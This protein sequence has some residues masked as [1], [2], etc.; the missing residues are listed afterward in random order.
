MTLAISGPPSDKPFAFYDLRSRSLRTWQDTDQKDSPMFSGTVPRTGSMFSGYLYEHPTPVPPTGGSD[1]SLQLPTPMAR[2]FDKGFS[3]SPDDMSRLSKLLPTP[4]AGDATA[5][6]NATATRCKTPPTGI[7]AGIT[8]TDF[9]RLLPT[10]RTTDAHGSGNHGT[11]G[12][13]LRTTIASL[14]ESTSRPSVVGRECL[15]APHLT[16][17][18]STRTDDPV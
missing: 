14:G 4:I 10:P 16:R 18:N 8:L 1:C 6:C 12:Q 3:F 9:I 15:G 7:H 2:D 11:G 5:T 13:D 17:L